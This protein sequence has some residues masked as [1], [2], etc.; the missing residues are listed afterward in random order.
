MKGRRHGTRLCASCGRADRLLGRARRWLRWPSARG[1]RADLASRSPPAGPGAHGSVRTGDHRYGVRARL[2]S[3][4]DGRGQPIHPRRGRLPDRGRQ[5]GP[6]PTPLAAAPDAAA[7][8]L[9]LLE[10]PLRAI[11]VRH[12]RDERRADGAAHGIALRS[13]SVAGCARRVSAMTRTAGRAPS[14]SQRWACVPAPAPWR[15]SW[16]VSRRSGWSPTSPSPTAGVRAVAGLSTGVHRGR[17]A[18]TG[19]ARRR[20]STS[21]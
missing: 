3:A 7:A 1:F 13:S 17:P 20:V 5:R 21:R 11:G 15:R 2:L 6:T 4:D 8:T 9:G 19:A 14:R 12:V 16:S 10:Q 18:P